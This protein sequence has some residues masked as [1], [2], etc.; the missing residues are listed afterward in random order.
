MSCY[1]LAGEIGTAMSIS[2]SALQMAE[3]II[4][5]LVNIFMAVYVIGIFTTSRA[6]A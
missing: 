3:V 1:P 4:S 5:V 2:Y 6:G